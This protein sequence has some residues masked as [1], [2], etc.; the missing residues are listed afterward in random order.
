MMVSYQ[1]ENELA[2]IT[3]N[4]PPVNALSHGVRQGVFDAIA[5]AQADDSKAIVLLCE[6]RTFVA[7]ADISEFG[8]PMQEPSL[9]QVNAALES[10]P[11]PVI[12]AI[13][14]TALGGGFELALSCHY[15]CAV[16]SAAVGLPEVNLGLLPGA[17]GTQRVPRLIGLKAALDM[18][19]SGQKIGAVKA[20]ELGLIDRVLDGELKPAAMAY[21]RELLANGAPLRR[22]R[23]MSVPA[24]GLNEQ[25]LENYRQQLNK[26]KRGQEAPQKIVDCIS[27]AA[28]KTFDE[29]LAFERERFAECIASEQSAALRHIFFAERSAAKIQ[30]I[31]KAVQ[32]R[33]I[34][35]VGI[36]GAG[37]MG[38]GI[39]MVFANAGI[40][41][42][43]LDLN[44]EG[45]E[46]GLALIAK[47]YGITVSKGKLSEQEA[48][49]RQAR[50]SGSTDYESLADADLVIEAVFESMDVKRQVF[51]KLDEVC[52]P[53]AILATNTSYLDVNDI[54]ATTSRPQDVIGLHFFSP[55][56]VMRLLEVVRADKTADDVLATAMALGKRIG[57]VAVLAGVCYGFIGNRMLRQYGREAQ[58]CMIEGASPEQIDGVLT[59]F[60][61]AMGPLAV[62]DLAGLDIGYKARESLTEEQKGDPRTYCIADALVEQGRLG[63]KT[64]AGYYRY[65][66]QTRARASDPEVLKIIKEQAAKHGVHQRKLSDEEILDRHLLALINEGFRI[67]EEGIAQRSSDIDVVYV[68]GYGFPSYRGGPMFHAAQRG[69]KNVYESIM[70]LQEQTGEAHWS[71]APLLAQLVSEGKSLQDWESSKN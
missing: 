3:I 69:L 70:K 39:A 47:N 71:P 13:H 2:V 20:T 62:G 12:A 66:P 16:E 17:G 6:G 63:Q 54:A 25:A 8:K 59:R 51:S 1:Q 7:G 11:K 41:V 55:A 65:D 43:L 21:A 31:G 28:D 49:A 45:L 23:D 5:K 35:K 46:R 38:G 14:G 60:G 42:T 57:K 27:A 18:I 36:I 56:N 52:K 26:R 22:I 37:T 48:A 40:P 58:L 32:P 15:R 33:A 53:G 67:L 50:I 19:T 9:A 24:D 68:Y 61:M 44:E 34:S 10:S 4:N 30:G 29:G 64:G